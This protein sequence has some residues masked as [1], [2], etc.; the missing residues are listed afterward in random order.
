VLESITIQPEANNL[1][2]L[3]KKYGKELT[4][5]GGIGTQVTLPFGTP[6]Q[7]REEIRN[8]RKVLGKNGGLIMMTTKPIRP[9]A[10]LE[11]AVMAVEIIIEKARKGSPC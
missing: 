8:C 9:E 10:P 1:P 6:E 11:N 3:K 5:E 7:V 4:F 2:E